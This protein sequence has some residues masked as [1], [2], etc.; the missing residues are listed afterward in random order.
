MEFTFNS[1][2]G[3]STIDYCVVSPNLI[4]HIQ[5]FEVD[6][7]DR[8]LSDSHSPIILTLKT[9]HIIADQNENEITPES[10]IDYVPMSTKW[11][12]EK[13]LDFQ[14]KFDVSKI[15]EVNQLLD[16]LDTNST[17]QKDVDDIVKIFSNISITAGLEAGISKQVVN[18]G[19]PPR[20]KKQNK[21]WFDQDC[22]LKRK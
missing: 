10:D 1:S 8:N 2:G 4:P 13:K 6:I 7:L 5:D 9:N 19:R 16:A 20:P 3:S 11:C 18:N 17:N 12:T 22:H 21:P 15:E 14:S